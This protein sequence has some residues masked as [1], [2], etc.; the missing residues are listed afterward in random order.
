MKLW[1]FA[2]NQQV[3]G[4]AILSVAR[5]MT[6]VFGLGAN[7]FLARILPLNLLGEYFLV[8]SVVQ[9]GA[10][11]AMGG[12]S[13]SAVPLLS[14]A[15]SD[16]MRPILRG[17]GIYAGLTIVGSGLL[18]YF[19]FNTLALLI[20]VTAQG[21]GFAALVAV[22]LFARALAQVIAHILRAFGMMTLFGLFETLLFNGLFLVVVAAYFLLDLHPDLNTVLVATTLTALVVIPPSLIPLW[23][24][25][26]SIPLSGGV[27]LRDAVHISLP[28]WVMIVANTALADAHLWIVGALGSSNNAALFGAAIRVVRL[29]GLP[30]LAVN[31]AIGPR[32]AGLWRQGKIAELQYLL[33][34]TATFVM[35]IS[36]AVSCLF[37]LLGP[38]TLQIMFGASFTAAWPA[39]LILLG[40][41]VLNAITGSP[42]LLMTVSSAQ[43]PAMI[44]S[45]VSGAVGVGLSIFLGRINPLIGVS[46]G[47]AATVIV[48]NV[49]AVTYCWRRLGI[50][51]LPLLWVERQKK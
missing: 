4:S 30:L 24:L 39:F 50:Q 11:V 18:V 3:R 8:A 51:T 27:F 14:G 13:Q 34:M 5:I 43:R 32:V 26:R 44:F 46:I 47:S 16:S 37:L 6:M 29:I 7:M 15:A 20:G 42:I 17:I 31:M 49:L 22:W 35:L 9:V 33:R 21:S 36:V 10:L 48:Q 45:I 38:E 41:R 40:G 1:K 25:I 28:L 2:A 19:L 23:R 12:V